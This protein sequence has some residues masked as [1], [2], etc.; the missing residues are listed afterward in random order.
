MDVI[1]PLAADST[2]QAV[3]T[4]R[5]YAYQIWRTLLAW[6][7]LTPDD[8]LFIEGAEDFD[9][10]RAAGGETVQ[11]KDLARRITL[12]TPAVTEAIFHYWEHRARNPERPPQLRLLTTAGRGLERGRPFGT[13]TG[14]DHWDRCR[15]PGVDLASLRSFLSQRKWPVSESTAPP[16][17]R[18]QLA[19]ELSAFIA[20]SPDEEFRDTLV[21]AIHWDTGSDIQATVETLV[22][23]AAI[24]LGYRMQVMPSDSTKAVDRLLRHV[25]E[26][27]CRPGERRLLHVDLLKV[28]EEAVTQRVP[29]AELQHLRFVQASAFAAYS[30]GETSGAGAVETPFLAEVVPYRASTVIPRTAVLS[31]A[32]KV[33]G[34]QGVLILSG[35]TGSGK[36]VLAKLLALKD[37]RRW[38]LLDFRGLDAEMVRDRLREV[39]VRP[40]HSP[41]VASYIL[42]DLNFVDHTATYENTL[43]AFVDAARLEGGRVVIT[44]HGV[45]PEVV[46]FQCNLRPGYAFPVPAL[47]PVEVSELAELN[48]CPAEAALQWGVLIHAFTHGH[49]QLAHAKVRA[50]QMEGWPEPS[51]IRAGSAQDVSEIHRQARQRLR[52]ELPNDDAHTLAYRLS[53]FIAPFRRQHALHI[54]GIPVPGDVFD[55]LV[56]PWV[57]PVNSDYFRVSPLL[58]NVAAEIFAQPQMGELHRAAARALLNVKPLTAAEFGGTLYHGL[59]GEDE[60]ALTAIVSASLRIRDEQMSFVA[61]SAPWFPTIRTQPGERL[62]PPN[63][64]TSLLLRRLQFALAVAQRSLSTAV[65]IAAA[66]ERELD[67]APP[68]ALP[69]ARASELQLLFLGGTLV[70]RAVPFPMAE[71][72]RRTAKALRLL[73]DE[74]VQSSLSLLQ[75]LPEIPTSTDLADLFVGSAVL[76][77]TGSADVEELLAVLS[78]LSP[79]DAGRVLSVFER[80]IDLPA[81][82]LMKPVLETAPAD[83]MHVER[84]AKTAE[85]L[86]RG[87]GGYGLVAAAYRARA[88]VETDDRG[89]IDA[90]L[91]ILDEGEQSVGAP[92]LLLTEYRARTM[93]AARRYAEAVQIWESVFAEWGEGGSLLRAFG[94]RDAAA[95]AGHAGHWSKM[96]ELAERGET[97]LRVTGSVGMAVGL[98]ADRAYALWKSGDSYGAVRTFAEVLD[99]LPSLPDPLADLRSYAVHKFVGHQILWALKHSRGSEYAEDDAGGEPIPG[100]ASSPRVPESIR[101]LPLAPVALTWSLLADLEVACGVDAGVAH[102]A[103][104]QVLRSHAPVVQARAAWQ[105]LGRSLRTGEVNNLVKEL[106]A[107]FGRG[108]RLQR[109]VTEG[110][111]SAG[112]ADQDLGS[113]LENDE[114]PGESSLLLVLGLGLLAIEAREGLVAAPLETW[115]ADIQQ[116]GVTEELLGSWMHLADPA[117]GTE[118]Q[119]FLVL[120]STGEFVLRF[121][122]A[123]R[124]AAS[125]RSPDKCFYAHLT[126]FNSISQLPR[127][128]DKDVEAHLEHV[129]VLSWRR[130]VDENRFALRTP[131]LSAPLIREACDDPSSGMT[132]VARVLLAARAAVSVRLPDDML[133]QLREFSSAG[134]ES[135]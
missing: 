66:W 127:G 7:Q 131:A 44:T 98:R 61:A 49:P 11:V 105:A 124:I 46:A 50:L 29:L 37:G 64:L 117:E 77:C 36:S 30:R 95:A 28:F 59:F 48:G 5:G 80:N 126:L 135:R 116:A 41:F 112:L 51:P 73:E 96:A 74:E 88:L 99:E 121:A 76:R 43:A 34:E 38:R 91:R 128:W 72:V 40:K 94:Y 111:T 42:D 84:I 97:L 32:I 22:E 33:L 120:R 13:E 92:H 85:R 9:I 115:Q 70:A 24:A 15:R 125:S 19:E 60:A 68:Q 79:D 78:S 63:P 3:S 106:L 27:A 53:V 101:D 54:A 55:Q 8:V 103:N 89:D 133:A 39:M 45:L 20:T 31:R 119:A 93:Y 18:A 21:R 123:V 2:R 109:L 14:F 57:E 75:Y 113:I 67:T 90:A 102:R 130:L 65:R 47:D 10:L 107:I 114:T 16:D 132:K 58:A 110:G 122:A 118:E 100:E 62:Y 25:W 35:S 69:D 87:G 17:E 86:G 129:V 23:Q 83:R 82:L 104:S 71:V 12:A 108:R 52:E 56:G 134:D 26:V 6:L 81:Q 4:L 1:P